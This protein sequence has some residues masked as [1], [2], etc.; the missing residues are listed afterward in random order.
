M[1][2]RHF[3]LGELHFYIQKNDEEEITS[4][5]HGWSPKFNKSD[6]LSLSCTTDVSLTDA[7]VMLKEAAK[8]VTVHQL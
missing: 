5:G 6:L 1:K 4:S 7:I 3:P 2:V 8:V